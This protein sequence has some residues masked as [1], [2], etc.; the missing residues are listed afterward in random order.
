M[1]KYMQA[2]LKKASKRDV[3]RKEDRSAE[4][5]RDKKRRSVSGGGSQRAE[6]KA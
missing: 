6:P 3:G 2:Q 1:D 5:D 4:R